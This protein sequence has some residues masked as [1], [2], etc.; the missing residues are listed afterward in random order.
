MS[1]ISIFTSK[2]KKLTPYMIYGIMC[3]VDWETD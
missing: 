1:V 2:N 3:F